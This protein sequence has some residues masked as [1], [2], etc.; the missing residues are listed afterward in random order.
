MH[1]NEL[2]EKIVNEILGSSKQPYVDVV[3]LNKATDNIEILLSNGFTVIP[4]GMSSRLLRDALNK[5]GD[6]TLHIHRW[7]HDYNQMLNKTNSTKAAERYA[8]SQ[9][10]NHIRELNKGRGQK[11][12]PK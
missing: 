5:E 9:H 6:T 4:I 1:A 12:D 8:K 3:R 2:A 7:L 11:K 10:S